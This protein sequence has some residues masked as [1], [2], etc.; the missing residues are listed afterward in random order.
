MRMPGN[1]DKT[2]HQAG[3]RHF[4]HVADIGVDGFG[5]TPSSAFEQAALALTGIVVDPMSV[6]TELTVDI[7]CNDGTGTHR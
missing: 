4:T 1:D 5:E 6:R 7:R 2:A 3:W